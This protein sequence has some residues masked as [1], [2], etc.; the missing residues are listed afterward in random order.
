MRDAASNE[1]LWDA[2]LKGRYLLHQQLGIWR[3]H[4]LALW[5][6]SDGVFDASGAQN[7]HNALPQSRV[8]TLP[9]MGHPPMMEA[10]GKTSRRSADFRSMLK[11]SPGGTAE[12]YPQK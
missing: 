6:A 12:G 10:H 5:G 1:R 7:L 2:Q 3:V 4:T 11:A 9:G 8:A